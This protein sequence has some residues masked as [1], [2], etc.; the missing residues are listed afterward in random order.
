MRDAGSPVLEHLGDN[1]PQFDRLEKLP[2]P[3]QI[4]RHV[5]RILVNLLKI[6]RIHTAILAFQQHPGTRS[7]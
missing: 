3:L 7:A 6:S 2:Q 4:R 5:I 1:P